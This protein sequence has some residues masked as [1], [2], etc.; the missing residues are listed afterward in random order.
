M[1]KEGR[2]GGGGAA[3]QRSVRHDTCSGVKLT[4]MSSPKVEAPVDSSG[5]DHPFSLP[6]WP[7]N[8]KPAS[9]CRAHRH[10]HMRRES[11]CGGRDRRW[12]PDGGARR[13]GAE[14]AS[15]LV[16]HRPSGVHALRCM[17]AV[18]WCAP[19]LG[20]LLWGGLGNDCQGS[21]GPYVWQCPVELVHVHAA[22]GAGSSISLGEHPAAITKP[23]GPQP[24]RAA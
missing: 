3:A 13:W 11:V 17:H 9:G 19:N 1:H 21:P 12:G 10:T 24:P 18:W 6:A 8:P 14:G 7:C 15:E 22:E 20:Q 23:H 16:T 5:M 4:P 2:G